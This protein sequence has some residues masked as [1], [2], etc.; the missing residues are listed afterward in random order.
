MTRISQGWVGSDVQARIAAHVHAWEMVKPL[1]FKRKL[2]TYPFVA[3]S[4]EYG[5][6]ALPLAQHLVQA[7]NERCLPSVPWVSYDRELLDKVSEELHLQR[8]ILETLDGQRRDEMSE[9]F[10]NIINRKV[11][12]AIVVR[13]L[14]EVIRTLAVHGHAVL[15]GRGSSLVT[16]DLRNGLHIRLVAPRAWR[17]HTVAANHNL[18]MLEAEK[19]VDLGEKHRSHYISTYFVLDHGFPFHHDLV[20]DNSR[21]NLMQIVEIIYAALN[22]RFGETLVNA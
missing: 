12:D 14:A 16:Q 2:E 21:F 3:I 4:R 9:L 19:R 11:D 6:E 18:S 17:I 1:G 22:A 20:I 8:D 5:C 10:D 13:K 15:V 7:L